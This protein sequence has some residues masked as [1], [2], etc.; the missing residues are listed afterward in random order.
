VGNYP[1]TISPGTLS[2]A[3]Y[4]FQFSSGT[5]TIAYL[6]PAATP[7]F[8]PAA[9]K[10]TSV[11]SVTISDATA[12]ATIYY[13]TDGSAPTI[14]STQYSSAIAVNTTETIE[15]IAVAPGY[16]DSAVATAKYTINLPS[17]T[18]TLSI[19][20]TSASIVSGASAKFTL[21]VTPQNGFAQAVSFSCSGEPSSDA[22]SFSPSSVTPAGIPASAAMTLG[23]A[24]AATNQ[25]LP[26][27]AKSAGGLAMALLLWPFCRRRFRAVFA[28]LIL[29]LA[30]LMISACI[31]LKPQI[32]TVTVTA[33]G[34]GVTQTGSIS[35]TVTK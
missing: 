24:A 9:G 5:L 15:A 28:L 35:L 6:G 20:P 30:G 2:A 12:S 34:G 8:S 29:L 13:T 16:D 21:T 22:C 10:C 18:F 4:T 31:I 1:I 32:Y 25:T 7:K 27:L 17:P 26:R 11:Q 14:G 33:S 3:H 23:P 19:S